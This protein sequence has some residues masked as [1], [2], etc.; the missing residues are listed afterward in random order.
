MSTAKKVERS[1]VISEGGGDSACSVCHDPYDVYAIGPCDHVV[2]YRCSTRMRVLC[3]QNECPICRSLMPQ[4]A[5]ICDKKPFKDISLRGCIPN[6]KYKIFFQTEEVEDKFLDLLEFHCKLC[7]N[8]PSDKSFNQLQTHMRREHQ[9]FACELCVNTLKI[10]PYERKFYSR[11]DLALHRRV[12]D[13]DDKSYKGHPL[14]EFCDQR[15]NDKDDLWKHLRKDHFYCHF[16]DQDCSN[17]YY[18]QYPDLMKHFEDHH[19]L[20]DEGEC[21]ASSCRFTHAFVSDIDLKAHK[22]KSHNKNMSK[23]QIRDARNIEVDFHMAP[24]RQ[25]HQ[26]RG[27]GGISGNDYEEANQHNRRQGPEKYPHKR[28]DREDPA[29]QRALE[30]SKQAAAEP[31]PSVE[32][33]V[34]DPVADFPT[35]SGA[36]A[37]RPASTPSI[38]NRPK[39]EDFPSLSSG[40]AGSIVQPSAN[41]AYSQAMHRPLVTK[42]VPQIKKDSKP[43][44]LGK[45]ASH[46]R[47]DRWSKASPFDSEDDYPTLGRDDYPSLGPPPSVA[48]APTSNISM[49]NWVD[50]TAMNGVSNNSNSSYNRHAPLKNDVKDFP[51]LGGGTRKENTNKNMFSEWSKNQS[52]KQKAPTPRTQKFDDDDFE[53]PDSYKMPGEENIITKS[54]QAEVPKGSNDFPGLA[55]WPNVKKDIVASPAPVS[56]GGGEKKKKKKK[57]KGGN[58]DQDS[59]ATLND[60]AS[61]LL[62]TE[63]KGS[64]NTSHNGNSVKPSSAKTTKKPQKT[65]WFDNPPEEYTANLA[66]AEVKSTQPSEKK[67]KQSKKDKSQEAVVDNFPSLHTMSA[68]VQP[69]KPPPG[70][71]SDVSSSK[72]PGLSAPPGFSNPSPAPP[73]RPVVPPRPDFIPNMPFTEPP[74]FRPRNLQLIKDIRIALEAVVDGFTNFKALSAEYRQGYCEASDYY[75]SCQHLM[76]K[77]DFDRVFPDLIALLPDIAKQQ[78][79]FYVHQMI[80]TYGS[81]SDFDALSACPTCSQV[82]LIKDVTH[83][84]LAHGEELEVT[85]TDNFPSLGGKARRSNNLG[86]KSE[87][88]AKGSWIKT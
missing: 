62:G 88:S 78:D 71:S 34:P 18:D 33:R 54:V 76:G 16:C 67:E 56:A 68:S 8:R 6:R 19:Y 77:A 39:P 20:C 63:Q 27:G 51:T 55:G 2:C 15:F 12:G 50:K 59:K 83:H 25:G 36:P 49:V 87:V 21:G 40:R 29:L 13:E 73:A 60:I 37:P 70:F 66:K 45:P 14:C 5:F 72:S 32:E 41:K 11:K 10:F 35:L 84:R 46:G 38:Y 48:K 61:G 1:R 82:V 31:R 3:E 47:N 30:E 85:S 86:P 80:G 43:V 65:D 53:L 75:L 24:R 42:H 57:N 4:V 64:A 23:A 44:S 58:S 69:T 81:I 79:L 9:L 74:E 26:G 22:A 52:Y 17:T 28:R 7:R